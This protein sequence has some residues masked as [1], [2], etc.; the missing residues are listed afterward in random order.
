[1]PHALALDG[2]GSKCD[3]VVVDETGR[4]TGWGRGG[5]THGYYVSPETVYQSYRDAVTQALGDLQS[6]GFWISGLLPPA[7]LMEIVADHGPVLGFARAGEVELGLAT[8]QKTWGMLVL[9]GTGS[10]VYGRL[11]DGQSR[12]FGSI[13]PILGDQG[14]AYAMGLYGLRAAFASRWTEARQTSLAEAVPRV[15]GL[16]NLY[17][18]FNLVYNTG[19]SRRE[20]AMAAEAVNEQAEAGDRVALAVLQGAADELA[21]LA[22]DIVNE[23][24][25]HSLPFPLIANGSVAQKSRLWWQRFT[26]R[27]LAAAPRAQPV[28]PD[29][30]PVVGGALL[31]L[32]A[33]G[34]EWSEQ[35]LQTIEHTQRP[36]L[37]NM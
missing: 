10:F 28:V 21:T 23:L 37:E 27:V 14:S 4:V 16:Q 24:Q 15:Y 17:E 19:L 36:Y 35:L 22:V 25:M 26:E 29:F 7:M 13:G 34:V 8:A 6:D 32:Q 20:I 12:H 9:S 11:P 1:M 5:S 2:G 30:K 18:V 33:M 31:A 3:A